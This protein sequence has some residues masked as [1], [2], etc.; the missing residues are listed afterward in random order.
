[1][2][3]SSPKGIS[4]NKESL[5]KYVM[6]AKGKLPFDKYFYNARLVDVCTERIWENA[7]VGIIDGVIASVCP[8]F[9]VKAAEMINC[10]GMYLAPSFIDAHMHIESSKLNPYAYCQGAVP[11]GTGCIFYDPMQIVNIAG[12]E[13]VKAFG[14]MLAELPLESYLQLPSFAPDGSGSRDFCSPERLAQIIEYTEACSFGEIDAAMLEDDE[15]LKKL[16]VALQSGLVINGHCPKM[17]HDN[18]CAAAAAGLADDHE[19]V[20]FDELFERLRCGMAVMVRQGTI[21]PDCKPLIKGVVEN[22]LPTNSLMFCTDDKAPE[23]IREN[24]CIDNAVRIAIACG[25]P[26]VKAI[27][28]ATLNAARHFHIDSVCGSCT[29]GRK[30]NFILLDD[31]ESVNVRNVYFEGRLAAKDGRLV[32]EKSFDASDYPCLKNSVILPDGLEAASF[33]PKLPH[34]CTGFMAEVIEMPEGGILTLRSQQPIRACGGSAVIDTQTDILPIAVMDRSGKNGGVGFGFI[35]GLGIKRG[36]VAASTAQEGNTLAVSGADCGDML[37]AV[38]E[39]AKMGGGAVICID[40]KIVARHSYS[41]GGILSGADIDDEIKYD[42]EFKNALKLTG[43]ENDRLMAVLTVSPC[44][45]IP[46]I[47]LTPK[48]LID[49]ETGSVIPCIRELFFE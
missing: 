35:K 19:C 36:A 13:G 8:D 37:T 14:K 43:S 45:T 3:F 48:G 6:A 47:G 2:I 49:A 21:E 7:S 24:G 26:P 10:S 5:K 9:E 23:D 1:M 31:L 40:G 39:T 25:M 41:V 11:H 30:A 16:S 44:S 46:Q 4:M 32:E 27:G 33:L 18:I 15:L 22:G 28:M 12:I 42:R 29:P 38:K 20:S 17:S 34:N